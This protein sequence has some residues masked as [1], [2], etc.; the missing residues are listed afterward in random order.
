[1]Y[2]VANVI[3]VFLGVNNGEIKINQMDMGL[4]HRVASVKHV[5]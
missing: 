1:M 5:F 3:Q 2:D 4:E